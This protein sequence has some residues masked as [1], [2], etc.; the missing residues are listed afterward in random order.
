MNTLSWI[1]WIVLLVSTLP[2]MRD[3][4]SVS[5]FVA[6]RGTTGSILASFG[7]PRLS[8]CLVPYLELHR[9]MH[10]NAHLIND[11]ILIALEH[12]KLMW[13]E[14]HDI[15]NMYIII[16]IEFEH[17]AKW[18]DRALCWMTC[19]HISWH[20]WYIKSGYQI[21]SFNNNLLKLMWWF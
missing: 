17:D 3:C 14:M 21:N 13:F 8:L 1:I 16:T 7:E 15:H 6:V 9:F 20:V 4:A 11:M 12:K 18:Y 19:L 5:H 2:C 10:L